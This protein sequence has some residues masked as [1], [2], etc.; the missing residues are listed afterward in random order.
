M[1]HTYNIENIL[2]MYDFESFNDL[3]DYMKENKKNGKLNLRNS[4]LSHLNFRNINFTGSDFRN[5]NFT[6]SDFRNINF[7][8]S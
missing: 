3:I 6:G 4:N 8:G 2:E 7:T 1:K 5:I